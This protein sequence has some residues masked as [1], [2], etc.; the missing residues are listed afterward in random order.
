MFTG[1]I[2]NT[3]FISEKK[4]AARST[5]FTFR[6]SHPEKNI[7][8]GESISVNGVCLTVVR[9]GPGGF[10]ADA[11][12]E[13]LKAT[14]LG[15][16]EKGREVNIERALR[17]GQ[18][19][20]GHFVTGHVDGKGKI[21]RI[22]EKAKDRLYYIKVPGGIE[23]FM[24]AKGSVTVDGVSLTIQGCLKGIISI[25]V[26]PH[27]LRS[28]TLGRLK[29]GNEVNIEADMIARY[30]DGMLSQPKGRTEGGLTIK[31]LSFQGF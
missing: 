11:V 12:G 24:A 25:T 26:I 31:G 22:E 23:H 30:L 3:A 15:L 1:I 9:G 14:T 17:A 2:Q 20:G 7:E 29:T 16:L 27:T 28:T 8:I 6:F 19:V 13:T 5:R 4:D 10:S 18:A 21:S